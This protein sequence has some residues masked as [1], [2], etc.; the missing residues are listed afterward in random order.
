VAGGVDAEQQENRA[1][2]APSRSGRD[3]V[4]PR[5]WIAFTERARAI[6]WRGNP[7]PPSGI[8]MFPFS[9]VS[10]RAYGIVLRELLPRTAD[11]AV[12]FASLTFSGGDAD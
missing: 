1:A 10:P 12:Q 2:E 3:V 11:I 7:S 9:S 4:K 6:A 8:R 5:A